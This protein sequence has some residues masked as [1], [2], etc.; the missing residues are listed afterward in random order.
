MGVGSHV[1]PVV[2]YKGRMA[3]GLLSCHTGIGEFGDGKSLSDGDGVGDGESLSGGDGIGDGESLYGGGGV[4]IGVSTLCPK[5]T[6]VFTPAA[7][8]ST[9]TPVSR[10]IPARLI[11]D[12]P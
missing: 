1:V 8:A 10:V 2:C 4:G 9:A 7:I 5:A 11:M 3:S 6:P 12:A